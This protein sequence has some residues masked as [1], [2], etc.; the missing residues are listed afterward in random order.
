MIASCFQYIV[1]SYEFSTVE[2]Q[3]NSRSTEA[4]FLDV[5]GSFPP[6]YI[7]SHLYYGFYP[8]PPPP[9]QKLF[10]TCLPCKHCIWKP[11]V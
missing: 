6:C 2:K 9:K 3:L 7:H 11:Q 8:S 10:E 5:I 1:H 4:E